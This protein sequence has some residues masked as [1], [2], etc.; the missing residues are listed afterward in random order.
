MA[1]RYYY[2][3]FDVGAAIPTPVH[4]PP[5]MVLKLLYSAPHIHLHRLKPVGSVTSTKLVVELCSTN[6]LLK[7]CVLCECRRTSQ[8]IYANVLNMTLSL[9]HD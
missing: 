8:S 4:T 3:S 7:Q 6:T 5:R 1:C 9:L 2:K